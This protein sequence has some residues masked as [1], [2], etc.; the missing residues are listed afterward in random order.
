MS[1]LDFIN[2]QRFTTIFDLALSQ[3]IIV[4]LNLAETGVFP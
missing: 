1:T 4:Q 2:T 3:A